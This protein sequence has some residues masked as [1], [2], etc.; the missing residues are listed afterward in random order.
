MAN[1]RYDWEAIQAEY[2]TGRFSLAQLSQ[3]HGPNRAS[4][5][6]KASAEGWQK[7]LTGAVQQRTR[8]KLS[9]PESAP[10]DAPDV[11]IIEAAASEN[12]T[13]V[14]G[15]REILTRWRSIASG[16]AQRMQEQL[17]RGKREAQLGT[18]DVI[19]IDLDLEY[20]GRCMGYG[21]Q[22]VE[23]VVKLERQS[24]GLDVES[25]DLPPERELTDD[26]IEAKIARL[27]GGDE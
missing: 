13:I 27:Q 9:R 16:F 3:R 11:E 15:H 26:E 2:R 23:R 5:S 7:D 6:R 12:A 22:A 8:E 17:D 1:T 19:E 21:T 10:P 14:R 4:I 18:G 25:D 20:I 24:Y